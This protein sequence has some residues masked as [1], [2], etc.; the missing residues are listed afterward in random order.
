[1]K[2]KTKKEGT[3]VSEGDESLFVRDLRDACTRGDARGK[4]KTR[5]TDI[6]SQSERP[7]NGR[8]RE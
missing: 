2:M 6:A 4:R 5:L 7:D 3:R 1:M 8:G